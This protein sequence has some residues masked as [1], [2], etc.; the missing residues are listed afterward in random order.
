MLPSCRST[1]RF[2][3]TK[4]NC[5]WKNENG[6][7][8]IDLPDYNPN[9][10]K[11]PYAYVVKI[12]NFGKFVSKPKMTVE[13]KPG[14]LQPMVTLMNSSGAVIHYT[15][16]GTEPT[17]S[18]PLYSQPFT[19]DKTSTVNAKAFQSGVLASGTVSEKIMKYEWMPQ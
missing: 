17:E 15:T 8:V 2:L 3:S 5:I 14:A 10:I 18:S 12:G 4:E 9:K 11:A 13:Y 6:N 19:I 7:A 16:D 1:I